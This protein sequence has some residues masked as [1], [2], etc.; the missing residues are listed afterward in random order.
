MP[1][2][3]TLTGLVR[4]VPR[5]VDTDTAVVDAA[6]VVQTIDVANGT[7]A[8]QANAYWR[9]VL[10]IA[11]GQSATVDLFA[12]PTT[13]F[14][15]TGTVALYQIKLLWCANRSAG[16]AVILGDACENRWGGYSSGAQYLPAGACVLALSAGEGY[17]A[18]GSSRNVVITND[19]ATESATVELYL[20]GVLD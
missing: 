3:F 19:S 13:A 6:T 2:T 11:A 9:D 15:G 4:M 5:W 20:A 7:G 12:L 16:A 14:G 1:R 18:D 17:A 10:T 8:G